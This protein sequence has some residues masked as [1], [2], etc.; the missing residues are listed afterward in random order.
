M[1]GFVV[2]VRK[3]YGL[4]GGIGYLIFLCGIYIFEYIRIL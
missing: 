1:F 4:V 2:D 3:I